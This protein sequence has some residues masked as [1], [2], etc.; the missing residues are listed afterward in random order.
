MGGGALGQ[1]EQR[2]GRGARAVPHRGGG[3]CSRAPSGGSTP[4][5]HPASAGSEA[6]T[7]PRVSRNGR[8]SAETEAVVRQQGRGAGSVPQE[9]GT[10]QE[11]AQRWERTASVVGP[12]A[13]ALA[14]AMQ[15]L[16]R[17]AAGEEGAA[18]E[19]GSRGLPG[20]AG[21]LEPALRALLEVSCLLLEVCTDGTRQLKQLLACRVPG[22]S[23]LRPPFPEETWCRGVGMKRGGHEGNKR[24]R[25][26]RR[27]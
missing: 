9:R 23:A 20:L 11:E 22:V 27:K 7:A 3:D 25:G 26:G 18:A 10:L 14:L 5:T 24:G 12:V 8:P 19:G 17:R 16:A 13:Q 1:G 15:D 4:Q 21:G 6:N 2:E